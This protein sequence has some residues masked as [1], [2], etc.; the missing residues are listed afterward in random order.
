ML[1]SSEWYT[2]AALAWVIHDYCENKGSLEFLLLRIVNVVITLEDEVRYYFSKKFYAQ[3]L[4]KKNRSH[5]FGYWTT[6]PP[7]IIS[8]LIFSQSKKPRFG[9]L[10]FFWVRSPTQNSHFR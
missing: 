9:T 5:I 7:S 4:V 8:F 6:L 3:A 1:T 10:I 2:V